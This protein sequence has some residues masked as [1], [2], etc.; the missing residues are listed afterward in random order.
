MK[1]I[2][3]LTSLLALAACAGGGS[4]GGASAPI[5][6]GN[7]DFVL[8]TERAA[9]KESNKKVTSVEY[10]NANEIIRMAFDAG[11]DDEYIRANA[12]APKI[13]RSATAR[14]SGDVWNDLYADVDNLLDLAIKYLESNFNKEIAYERFMLENIKF[15]VS[16]DAKWE[17]TFSFVTN[18]KTA[19]IEG[20][21]INSGNGGG[22]ERRPDTN[23]FGNY[24]YVA[25]VTFDN[26]DGTFDIRTLNFSTVKANMTIEE[27]RA[28]FVK[29]ALN[30]DEERCKGDADCLA[31]RRQF[32]EAGLQD[33]TMDDIE[34]TDETRTLQSFGKD[35]LSYSDFGIFKPTNE[36][37]QNSE[38]VA[39]AGVLPE[40][41]YDMA[42]V[43]SD[44]KFT[45]VATGAV[46]A[47]PED[48]KTW[49]LL[50]NGTAE[51]TYN[52]KAKSAMLDASF[53]NWYGVHVE[54]VGT[55]DN[56]ISLTGDGANIKDEKY[57]VTDAS[58]AAVRSYVE[59]A[60][61][62]WHPTKN[63]PIEAV[64]IVNMTD[65]TE[66]IQLH[67]SFGVKE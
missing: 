35:V 50:E 54:N 41:S 15:N 67:M 20:I 19:E 64:G 42:N 27:I 6:P 56:T 18:T 66:N 23:V 36:N 4:G 48:N 45:G 63:T 55:A 49:M 31:Q 21:T 1:K 43:N 29:S 39:F 24:N 46:V 61:Y 13:V 34:M 60:G 17:T 53:D 52:G 57:K 8:T 11:M 26:G 3:I 58:D 28:E 59:Y 22:L 9:A 33:L 62:K 40:R 10:D 65:K 38:P 2:A 12:A 16:D 25:D 32:F 14:V 5:I 47:G 37:L 7:T 30:G 44:L 51:L